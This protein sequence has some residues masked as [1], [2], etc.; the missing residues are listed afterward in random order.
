MIPSFIEK[1]HLLKAIQQ[2]S[3]EGVPPQRRSHDY[4]LVYDSRH[5]PPKYII[6]IAHKIAT[7][8]LLSSNEFSGG[9]E[10][11]GFLESRG[12]QVVECNCCG[13]VIPVRR[14]PRTVSSTS[15][16][17]HPSQ[18]A[19]HSKRCPECK[20]RVHQLLER[21]YGT[22]HSN[23]SFL[24]STQAWAYKGTP[25]FDTLQ[26]VLSALTAYR[27][28]GDF[29]KSER[30]PRCDFFV[31]DP[32]FLVEF[33]ESQ[34]FTIPR[35]TALSR[36]PPDSN[37]G[38]S[39]DRWISLCDEH[40]AKDNDPPYR[41][42]QRAWYDTLRDMVPPLHGLGPTIRIYGGGFPWCSLNP[43]NDN[44]VKKFE[45]LLKGAQN[46]LP[47]SSGPV[48]VYT[49]ALWQDNDDHTDEHRL[50]MLKQLLDSISERDSGPQLILL[51]GGYLG[52]GKD[53]RKNADMNL[54]TLQTQVATTLRQLDNRTWLCLGVDGEDGKDQLAVAVSGDGIQAVGRKFHPAPGDDNLKPAPNYLSQE[55]DFQRI[56]TFAGKHW[57]LAICYDVF[58]ISQLELPNPGV[59]AILNTV[60]QFWPRKRRDIPASGYVYFARLGFAGA[61]KAWGCPVFGTAVFFQQ[62]V[63]E[64]WPT[65]VLWK[66]GNKLPRQCRYED[67]Q[68]W[69]RSEFRVS[70]GAIQALVRH[71]VVS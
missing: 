41:D 9:Q 20:L 32:G 14:L 46:L 39:I 33:D 6:A 17:A 61:S 30:L 40:N 71:F 68:L 8:R 44:D 28:Y 47:A 57:Y 56:F 15:S 2:V 4:C 22:C 7:G 3:C 52:T 19:T 23:Y 37:V 24:W 59:D 12:F 1:E 29:I 70:S 67:N 58:G 42:E 27:G 48:S 34:H 38:F 69:P 66:S 13:T 60:H 5:Y 11:N 35:K 54:V 63:P 31:P 16:K 51:P 65:A 53:R 45:A 21:I 55:N 25:I 43:Q 50:D 62:P 26:R 10:S 18:L 64:R 49:V 36:Y